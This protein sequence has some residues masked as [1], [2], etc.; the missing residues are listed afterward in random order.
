MGETNVSNP[1]PAPAPQPT[2]QLTPEQALAKLQAAL[3]DAQGHLS[4]SKTPSGTSLPCNT[5]VELPPCDLSTLEVVENRQKFDLE[6]SLPDFLGKLR[7]EI[8]TL[9]GGTP[10]PPPAASAASP[11]ERTYPAKFEYTS[12]GDAQKSPLRSGAVLEV[13]ALGE[14][15][16]KKTRI[17]LVVRT[18]FKFC[19]AK[20]HHPEIQV[21]HPDG[22]WEK[23]PQRTKHSLNVYRPPRPY[24]QLPGNLAG[25]LGY[26]WSLSSASAEYE[27]HAVVC[28]ARRPGAPIGSQLGRI[29]VYPA[30]QYE[31]TVTLPPIF[32][33]GYERYD[34]RGS[35]A[36][37][38]SRELT[39]TG[40][41]PG[42]Q[43]TAQYSSETGP[44]GSSTNVSVTKTVYGPLS[45]ASASYSI[46]S[47]DGELS[48]TLSRTVA[49]DGLQGKRD[50]TIDWETGKETRKTTIERRKV[51][52]DIEVAFKHN[53]ATLDIASWITGTLNLVRR[54]SETLDEIY[55][56]I[57]EW[58]PK[59]GWFF[60]VDVSLFTG[61]FGV[62]WG[63][64]EWSDRRVF[65][66]F[67]LYAQL[68]LIKAGIKLAF[69]I[70]CTIK[71]VG[72]VAKVEGG[73]EGTVSVKASFARVSPDETES[74]GAALTGDIK[75]SLGFN[76]TAISKGWF[77]LSGTIE[78]SVTVEGALKVESRS[79]GVDV[80]KVMWNGIKAKGTL[81]VRFWFDS[82]AEIELMKP[83]QL[84]GPFHYP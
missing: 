31:F 66:A 65:R 81:H 1:G 39:A 53:G 58:K 14:P 74:K 29:R 28:G 8:T 12:P 71:G 52:T 46:N 42:L 57:Q 36:G 50:S 25:F 23:L 11:Q 32:K 38:G 63:Y 22:R 9:F 82:D 15:D 45:S 54:F 70:D 33:I 60:S 49:A 51:E 16:S 35:Q 72:I 77:E 24:D 68:E 20:N 83:R 34:G 62:S 27:V 30:D 61:S 18:D 21:K 84:G 26:F 76:V 80:E 73:L 41:L 40:N 56:A 17:D 43:G 19:G 7:N 47:K 48:D 5:P 59:V 55:K 79:V 69:G 78:T 6:W 4:Q 37:V 67:E 3:A 10:P 64:K 13:V 44:E 2:P 75:G